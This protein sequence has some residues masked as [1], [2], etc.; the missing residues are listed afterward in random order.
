[1]KTIVSTVA[2]SSESI[3]KKPQGGKLPIIS[4]ILIVVFLLVTLGTGYYWGNSTGY[5]AGQNV[6][7]DEGYTDGYFSGRQDGYDTGNEYGFSLSRTAYTNGFM[8][9]FD[10]AKSGKNKYP[11][12]SGTTDPYYL[13]YSDGY[14]AYG[15]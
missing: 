12:L 4:I 10:E 1:M 11:I 7:Y 13:G 14:D 3:I 2:S 8:D 5:S 9:G 15:K 6:G